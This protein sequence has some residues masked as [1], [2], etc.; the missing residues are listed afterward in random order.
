MVLNTQCYLYLWLTMWFHEKNPKK[1]WKS[2]S[3]RFYYINW[4]PELRH[5]Q[6]SPK[7]GSLNRDLLNFLYVWQILDVTWRIFMSRRFRICMPKGGRG[8]LRPSY[9]QP[10]LT[11]LSK[12]S[13]TLRCNI[14]LY[15]PQ[16]LTMWRNYLSG[17]ALFWKLWNI[18]FFVPPH[19]FY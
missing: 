19:I 4:A 2:Q 6:N 10:K 18:Q 1:H 16:F 3:R 15:L 14:K 7:N 8:S 5:D 9:S 11:L 13:P 17:Q 12:K